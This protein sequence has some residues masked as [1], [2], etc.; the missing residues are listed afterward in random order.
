MAIINFTPEFKRNY[1]KL[2]RKHYDMQKL[3]NVIELLETEKFEKLKY[4]FDDHSLHG[5]YKGLRALHVEKNR[6]GN[7]ILIYRIKN[8]KIQMIAVDLIATGNHE[9]YKKK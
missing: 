2:K 4:S 6:R 8:K 3:K 5:K 1:K 9:L 7:W